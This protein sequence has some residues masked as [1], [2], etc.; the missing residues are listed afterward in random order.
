[1]RHRLT[2]NED[3]KK[4]TEKHVYFEDCMYVSSSFMMKIEL[5]V[6]FSIKDVRSIE[7]LCAE[8]N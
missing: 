3:F 1:M 4:L 8:K 2:Y 7:Y 6:A 5:K